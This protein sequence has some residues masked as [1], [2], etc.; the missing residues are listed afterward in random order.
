M[1]IYQYACEHCGH[2]LEAIQKIAD[3]QL[4]DCPKCQQPALKK[5]VT[6][7]AFK[8]K[9]T[10]WYETDFKGKKETPSKTDSSPKESSSS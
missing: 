1:P 2:Q 10:G 4:T 7:A 5:Q 6:A 8:L 9:G 3:A